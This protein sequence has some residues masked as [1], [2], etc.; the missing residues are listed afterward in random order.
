MIPAIGDT[1]DGRYT[2]IAQYRA[3]PGLSAWIA[4]D[5]ALDQDCQIFLL[6]DETRIGV[7]S[8]IASA[9]VLS[10]NPRSTAV[11]RFHTVGDALLVVMEPD[12]GTA[13]STLVGPSNP[14]GHLSFAA[15]RM[16]TNELIDT[17]QSLHTSQVDFH[18]LTPEVIR[19]TDDS[20]FLSAVPIDP[21]IEPP[22]VTRAR[23]TSTSSEMLAILQISAVLFQMMTGVT[24]DPH[25]METMDERLIEARHSAQLRGDDL[26]LDFLTILE[27]ALGVRTEEDR[28]GNRPFPIYTLMEM[29]ALLDN[30]LRPGRLGPDAPQLPQSAGTSSVALVHLLP[31]DQQDLA[32]IP[33]S[34]V[35]TDTV[36]NEAGVIAPWSRQELFTGT[37][38]QEVDPSTAGLLEPEN[39][40]TD[41][42]SD[43]GSDEESDSGHYSAAGTSRADLADMLN[44]QVGSSD[45]LKD[46]LD[47]SGAHHI[48]GSAHAAGMGHGTAAAPSLPLT[49][50]PATPSTP[51][52]F[53]A[54]T[55][56]AGTPGS[57]DRNGLSGA[58]H[59]AVPGHTSQNTSSSARFA[60][61]RTP[62]S[63]AR[64]D[65]DETTVFSPLDI[66]RM[67]AQ[68]QNRARE[69]QGRGYPAQAQGQA[70]AQGRSAAAGPASGMDAVSGAQVPSTPSEKHMAAGTR[71][72]ASSTQTSAVLS[73][74]VEEQRA[75]RSAHTQTIVDHHELSAADSAKFDQKEKKEKQKKENPHRLG[76][77]I[78][79]FI[80]AAALLAGGAL[81][82][83]EL[84][85]T[86]NIPLPW[87][88]QE[89]DSD[90]GKNWNI[91]A[92][93]APLPGNAKQEEQEQQEDADD[94][95]SGSSESSGSSSS[96]T[97]SKS[98]SSSK[99]SSKKKTSAKAKSAS[100]G[101]KSAASALK[102]TKNASAV[103]KPVEPVTNP[104]QLSFTQSF[105]SN[106]DGRGIAI[107]LN[108]KHRVSQV[109]ITLRGQSSAGTGKLYIDSTAS[110][111]RHG[112]PVATFTFV[113]GNQPTKITLPGNP[114][115][116]SL[117][118]WVDQA[119][120]NG[121]YYSNLSVMGQ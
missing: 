14:H 52:S 47:G 75:E 83:H 93:K 11:R 17:I 10:H 37:D 85:G 77:G 105:F 22:L 44:G 18:T 8:Q 7:V 3:Q 61:S 74:A 91:D 102:G 62:A 104:V 16:V 108:G 6:T 87:S 73:E 13:L 89:K 110:D 119:P 94:Q 20:L 50:V 58:P 112:S 99:N 36:H 31:S 34:L 103:P 101:T 35:S 86:V 97:S 98:S 25:D 2:L 23:Q 33:D 41:D 57:A 55:G 53:A 109:T 67:E 120:Q 95:S 45:G 78:V 116:Q 19:L 117:V 79:I 90:I 114:S 49:G 111:P 84:R 72:G 28:S 21:Y 1:L 106:N 118:I 24:F 81:A 65:A 68:A 32:D 60:G 39:D 15:M 63:D 43:E 100:S 59:G 12:R 66:R 82:V 107:T 113:G 48:A 80:A 54:R 70:Q 9:L 42:G 46:L 4:R 29:Q 64:V 88:R 40:G 92:S 121:L 76:Q 96:G 51:A 30:P 115:T 71:T 69:T 56:S 26:P 38:V 27:R 5:H